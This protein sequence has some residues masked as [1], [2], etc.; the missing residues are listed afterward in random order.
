MRKTR[1]YTESDL[2]TGQVHELDAIASHHLCTVLRHNAGDELL[3]FN[4]RED[5]EYLARLSQPHKKHARVE[6]LE[7]REVFNESPLH[8]HLYQGV[9]RGDRMDFAVQ[10]A[11]E[12]GVNEI[13]PVL[14]QHSQMRLTGDK[15]DKKRQ[16][17]QQIAISASQQCGRCR[18]PNV[19]APVSFEIAMSARP[20]DTVG[21]F[22]HTRDMSLPQPAWQGVNTLDI[23]VGPEGGFDESEVASARKGGLS[24]LQL[25]PR[26][27]RTE[28][29]AIAALTACQ[30]LAGDMKDLAD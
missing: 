30:I 7:R 17:W 21:L 28:T 4:G 20:S 22:L 24:A 23:W 26:V 14:C 5:N 29:A 8:I 3:L 25:G 16:H 2:A 9:S 6:V 10:K 13:T 19:H 12:L 18:L 15:A 11:T 1:L 27:L